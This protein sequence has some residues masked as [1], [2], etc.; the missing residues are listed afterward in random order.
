MPDAP[1]LPGDGGVFI[2]DPQIEFNIEKKDP[3][4]SSDPPPEEKSE[5]QPP[6]S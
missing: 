5:R 6:G 3:A 2:P 1:L 4:P